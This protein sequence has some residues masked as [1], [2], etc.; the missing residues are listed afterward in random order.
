MSLG[1]FQNELREGNFKESFTQT[2]VVSLD[3]VVTWEKCYIK[4]NDNNAEKKAWDA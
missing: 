3:E 1:A 4:W 2:L